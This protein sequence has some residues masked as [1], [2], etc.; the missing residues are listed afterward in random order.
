MGHERL[1]LRFVSAVGDPLPPPTLVWSP[2]VDGALIGRGAHAHLRLDDR[3][4]SV[5]HVRL[6]EEAG[7]LV[8]ENLSRRGTTRLDGA[9]LAPGEQASTE[10]PGF[11]Q[12]GRYCWAV[13]TMATTLPVSR[14]APGLR[15]SEPALLVLRRGHTGPRATF[16]GAPLVVRA[17]ALRF[18]WLLASEAGQAIDHDRLALACGRPEPDGSPSQSGG[19]THQAARALRAALDALPN[20]TDLRTM[21]APLAAIARTRHPHPPG[22]PPGAGASLGHLLVETIPRYGYR[23]ALP[24]EHVDHGED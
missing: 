1:L 18:L 5:E 10:L 9:R 22:R 19:D 21:C 16:G 7:R 24:L 13:E 23:L 2:P 6:R 12:V 17:A 15:A 14:T 8:L 4:V 20:A 11:L 3:S